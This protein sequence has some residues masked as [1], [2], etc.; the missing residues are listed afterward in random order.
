[1]KKEKQEMFIAF[2]LPL[3]IVSLILAGA[4]FGWKLSLVLFLLACGVINTDEHD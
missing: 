1:M 4:W 2:T 3:R